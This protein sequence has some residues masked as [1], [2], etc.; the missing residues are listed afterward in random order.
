MVGK[1]IGIH[2]VVSLVALLAGGELFGIWVALFAAPIAG[3]I[4]AFLIAIWYEWHEIHKDEFQ[5]VKD[6]I[7]AEVEK[8]TADKPLDSESENKLLS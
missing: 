5:G 3:V 1:V 8:H 4:Q 2:P 6:K 7:N